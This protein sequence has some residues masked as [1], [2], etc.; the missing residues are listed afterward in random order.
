MTPLK[1]TAIS[2]SAGKD[3]CLALLR[4]VIAAP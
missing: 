1:K 3:A 4:A 2:R